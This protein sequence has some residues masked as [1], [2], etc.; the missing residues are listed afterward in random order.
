MKEE[1]G[2]ERGCA[3]PIPGRGGMRC[4]DRHPEQR[5]GCAAL[6]AVPGGNGVRCPAAEE[7]G[8]CAAPK[9]DRKGDV[10]P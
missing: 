5:G 4:S 6:I 10:L 1:V 8:G 3:A 7:R 2:R 9:P